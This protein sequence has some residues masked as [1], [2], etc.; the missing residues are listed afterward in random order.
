MAAEAEKAI[1]KH[2]ETIEPAGD[3]KEDVSASDLGKASGGGRL[4]QVV[5]VR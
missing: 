3:K 2:Q 1:E 5:G 4:R